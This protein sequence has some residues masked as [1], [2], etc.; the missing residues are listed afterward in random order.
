MRIM[1]WLII[2]LCVLLLCTAP[3]QSYAETLRLPAGTPVRFTFPEEI[4][5]RDYHTGEAVSCFVFDDVKIGAETVIRAGTPAVATVSRSEESYF[6]GSAGL[7][8]VKVLS[9]TTVDGQQVQIYAANLSAGGKEKTIESVAVAYI[10]CIFALF[11][12]GD[13]GKIVA[14]SV[15]TGYT[16]NQV[17]IGL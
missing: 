10:C 2:P 4:T 6:V 8:K 12:R 13:E 14:N 15:V 1:S 7:I 3:I 5:S 11:M 17:E 9:T 16:M